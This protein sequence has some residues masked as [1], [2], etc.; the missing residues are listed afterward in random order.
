MSLFSTPSTLDRV[1]DRVSD[2]ADSARHGLSDARS[3]VQ[4]HLI[5]PVAHSAQSVLRHARK[6]YARANDWASDNP[7]RAFGIA[8][9]IGLIAGIIFSKR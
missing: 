8:F 3:A 9:G 6:D 2:L 7:A 4:D 5:D 1:K